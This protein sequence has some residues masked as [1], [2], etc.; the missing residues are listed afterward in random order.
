MAIPDFDHNHVLPPH[1][2]SPTNRGHLSP[3]DCSILELCQK[4]STSS[5]RIE[6]LK[7]FL[8]FRS[9]MNDLGIINGFQWLDGSFIENIEISEDRPPNDLDIVTFFGGITIDEQINIRTNF[10]EF[11]DPSLAKR[12]FQLDHYPVD[13][14]Y[15]PDATVEMT[16]YWIQLFTHNRS[17]VW[18]G[19]LKLPLNTPDEDHNALNYLKSL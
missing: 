10:P 18:K 7:K 9:K 8:T 1:I 6:I 3:Y 14:C 11:S 19:I 12:N 5:I 2:G 4:F 17:G 16:R 13:Y 15:T